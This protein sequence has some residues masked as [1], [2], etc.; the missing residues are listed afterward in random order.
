MGWKTEQIVNVDAFPPFVSGGSSQNPRTERIE[1]K[2]CMT[3]SRFNIDV[4]DKYAYDIDETVEIQVEFYLRTKSTDIVLRYDKNGSISHGMKVTLP[5]MGDGNNWYVHKF[6]LDRARFAGRRIDRFSNGDFSIGPPDRSNLSY[7]P[8]ISICGIDIKR[9]Y[10]TLVP[11]AYGHLTLKIV[12]KFGNFSPARIGIYDQKNRMPL[13]SDEAIP[14][15]YFSDLAKA[16]VL[17][18]DFVPWPASNRHAF[19]VNG[20][21]HAKLPVGK[22]TIVVGQ[23]LEYRFSQT[24]FL[25]DEDE[26]TVVDMKLMRWRDMPAEGW[27]SGD[28]HIHTGRAG[29]ENDKNL[30]LQ[31]HAEDLHVANLLQMGNINS[32]YYHQYSGG[33]I[34]RSEEVPFS[35]VSGQEDPRS[36]RLGHTIHLNIRNEIL[37]S[38]TYYLYHKVFEETQ[39]QGGLGGYAHGG[40]GA[41]LA[42]DLPF[43]LVD[44]IEVLQLNTLNVDSWFDTL[45]LGYKI[46][47]AAGTDYPYFYGDLPGSVRNYVKIGHPYSVQGWFDGLKKGH[48][49]VTNGPMLE[50]SING[51]GMGSD[52]QVA[53]GDTLVIKAAAAINPDVGKLDRIELIQQGV[54]VSEVIADKNLE[55]L[56]LQHTVS[57][58][59]GS[60]FMVRAQGKKSHSNDMNIVAI[61]APIYVYASGSGFCKPS[62]IPFILGEFQ[63]QL[64]SALIRPVDDYIETEPWDSWEDRVKYWPSNKTLLANR[65]DKG[66]RKYDFILSL[67]DKQ[68]CISDI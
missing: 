11:A 39:K 29:V 36:F 65:I 45:N 63:K 41:G 35:L 48:T 18:K 43:G 51:Q 57:L 20:R 33:G 49:F 8:E 53:N 4:I 15:Q 13:P 56:H 60:W 9:S 55:E 10:T 6:T 61:S 7:H 66:S 3:A 40:Y 64:Q 12:D 30:R 68:R 34:S 27:Y 46:S 58:K 62:E 44:F 26:N 2:S 50:F 21:Y 22:Y 19:Y 14:I 1:G 47:P 67:S 52:V 32:T 17:H 23:G 42:L 37:N 31:M 59:H 28:V 54:V 25:I 16:V 24:T 5:K 38:K